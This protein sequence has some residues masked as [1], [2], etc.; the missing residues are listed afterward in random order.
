MNRQVGSY[1]VPVMEGAATF[2]LRIVVV[3]RRH[4]K[5]AFSLPVSMRD[6]ELSE[7]IR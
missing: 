2:S 7:G 5:F 3:S 6:M 4:R 1:A